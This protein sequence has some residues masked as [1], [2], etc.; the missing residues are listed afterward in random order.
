MFK[1]SAWGLHRLIKTFL[2]NV[3]SKV[4][5]FSG[6]FSRYSYAVITKQIHIQENT[7]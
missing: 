6:Q 1:G 5:S 3:A 7:S 4:S 2:G